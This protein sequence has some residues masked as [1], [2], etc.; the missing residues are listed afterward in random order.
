MFVTTPDAD[1]L[2]ARLTGRGTETEDVISS[3]L[4]RAVEEANGIENYDYLIVNDDL[5]EAV[6][7]AHEIIQGEHY[8]ISRNIDFINAVRKD[9]KRFS[10]GE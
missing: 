3:R 10:K 2:K 6:R 8:R 5:D 4:A 7:E 1:T 9:L